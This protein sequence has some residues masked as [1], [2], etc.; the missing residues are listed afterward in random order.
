MTFKLATFLLSIPLWLYF[1]TNLQWYSYRLNRVIFKAAKPKW[2]VLFFV[3]PIIIYELIYIF[4]KNDI[5]LISFTLCYIATFFLWYKKL[6]KQLV[7]TPRIKRFFTIYI[8]MLVPPLF[9][10]QDKIEILSIII[11]LFASHYFSTLIE[12]R[13]ALIYENSAIAKLESKQDRIVIAITASYG[14][15]SIKNIL[16]AILKTK[17]SVYATPRSVNTKKGVMKDINES[18]P[19]DTQI[20]IVEAGAREKGDIKE[21]ADLVKPDYAIIGKIGDAHLD[22]FKSIENIKNTKRELLESSKLKKAF[23]YKNASNQDDANIYDENQIV[24]LKADLSGLSFYINGVLYATPLLGAFNAVNILAA[25]KVAKELDVSD[26]QISVALAK[27]Q[28]VEHRL[29]KIEANGKII[30]DDSFNG[31]FEGISE[32]IRLCATHSGYKV[33]IT[34]GIVEV[35][36]SVNEKIAQ[37]INEVFDLVIITGEINSDILDKNITKPKKIILKDKTALTDI[38]AKETSVGSVIYFANDAPNFI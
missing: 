10:F 16:A 23:I 18:M 9:L 7:F 6:D 33:I 22:Y 30:L 14:K 35:N 36:S 8:A 26:E 25:I 31:N 13:F 12:A 3:L 5:F 4:F 32:G 20:Y 1:A 11:A 17:Y 24:D 28:P 38:L 21:I 29:Q 37:K 27:M 19:I 2:H 34:P 15:T